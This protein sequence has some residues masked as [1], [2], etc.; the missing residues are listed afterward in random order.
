MDYTQPSYNYQSSADD[1]KGP[2]SAGL[3]QD[4]GSSNLAD[5]Y[6]NC[7]FDNHDGLEENI[8]VNGIVPLRESQ[9]YSYPA[10]TPP[11][12]RSAVRL[13]MSSKRAKI[14]R[15]S[16]IDNIPEFLSKFEMGKDEKRRMLDKQTKKR[17]EALG[18][19]NEQQVAVDDWQRSFENSDITHQYALKQGRKKFGTSAEMIR[20]HELQ[21]QY[22]DPASSWYLFPPDVFKK[23]PEHLGCS[24][25]LPDDLHHITDWRARV[26]AKDKRMEK[27]FDSLG[28]LTEE[29]LLF[30][31]LKSINSEQKLA[32]L[33]LVTIDAMRHLC[34]MF[35]NHGKLERGV[36][37]TWTNEELLAQQ[38]GEDLKY[39]KKSVFSIKELL[40]QLRPC[41]QKNPERGKLMQLVKHMTLNPVVNKEWKEHSFSSCYNEASHPNINPANFAKH[42]YKSWP[43]TNGKGLFSNNRNVSRGATNQA[44]N[45]RE[46]N[47][48]PSRGPQRNNFRGTSRRRGNGQFRPNSFR[49]RSNK[50]GNY[51]GNHRGNYRGRGRGRGRGGGPRRGFPRR[52]N[53]IIVPTHTT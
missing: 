33:P 20:Q 5:L 12:K 1:V 2:A 15:N 51:R 10:A 16:S 13:E 32:N 45:K 49:G 9:K 31:K 8:S 21:S 11:A 53:N 30:D 23:A 41:L 36:L 48:N 40:V 22:C 28:T 46:G 39:L 24:S 27:I 29:K 14:T 42:V 43:I 38:Q 34:M 4:S 47:F 26:I 37:D 6:D 35:L 19:R 18:V 52:M 3:T 7:E 44:R 25:N 50:R 17:F